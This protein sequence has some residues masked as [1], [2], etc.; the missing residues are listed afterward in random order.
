MAFPNGG[1]RPPTRRGGV[2]TPTSDGS[3]HHVGF[4][5]A[6]GSRLQ[7]RVGRDP[8]GGGS[9]P[10]QMMDRLTIRGSRSLVG[11]DPN[12]WWVATAYGVSDR[13]WV[14]TP[15]GGGSRPQ[16][17]GTSGRG[18]LGGTRFRLEY[19]VFF[20]YRLLMLLLLLLLSLLFEGSCSCSAGYRGERCDETCAEGRFGLNCNQTCDCQKDNTYACDPVTGA[21]QCKAN[22][23]GT[24]ARCPWPVPGL[25]QAKNWLFLFPPP[26]LAW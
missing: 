19:F 10:P 4:P 7:G 14:V 8:N 1:S 16:G 11:R 3:P 23:R 26:V 13:W 15:R 18:S 20:Y 2:V 21:C 9:R 24:P 5:I 6:G 17:W 25:F 12:G 22:F